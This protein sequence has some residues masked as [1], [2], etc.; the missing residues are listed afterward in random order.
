MANTNK[1]VGFFRNRNIFG[2]VFF[3]LSIFLYA[4]N[5]SAAEYYDDYSDVLLV[6]NDN[7]EISGQIADYFK[8]QRN[9]PDSHVVHLEC[10]TNQSI[11]RTEFE[12]SVR[13]PIEDFLTNNN[14]TNQINYIVLTKDVPLA[15]ANTDGSGTTRNAASVDS[16]LTLILGDYNSSLGAKGWFSNPYYNQE[17]PFS[18]QQFGFYLVTRLDGYTYDDIKALIDHATAADDVG[19]FVLDSDNNTNPANEYYPYDQDIVNAA[20]VIEANGYDANLEQTTTFLRNQTNV[21][22]YASWGSNSSGAA[23]A[24]TEGQPHVGEPYN[25]WA[26]GA[27]GDTYVSTSGRTFDYAESNYDPGNQSLS[28]DLV[29][30]GITGVKGYVGEPYATAM[31][32]SPILFGRYTK[33]YNLADSFYMASRFL[34]WQ[35]VVIGD[36]KTHI[37]EDENGFNCGGNVTCECGDVVTSNITLTADLNCTGLTGLIAGAANITI[38]GNGHSITGDDTASTN[39]IDITGFDNI[40]VKNFGDVSGF[41][42]GINISNSDSDTIKDNTLSSNT[43][44]LVLSSSTGDDINGNTVESNTS[45][46]VSLTSSEADITNN[47]ISSND[48]GLYFS[49]ST[50]NTTSSNTISSN[51]N[52]GIYLINS[53]SND[54]SENTIASQDNAG[55]M[56]ITSDSNT[57]SENSLSQ[58]NTGISFSI[59]YL[60]SIDSNTF[61]SNWYCLL[62]S[63]GSEANYNTINDNTFTANFDIVSSIGQ[64]DAYTGNTFVNN[65]NDSVFTS[66]TFSDNTFIDTNYQYGAY[67]WL[68]NDS[69]RTINFGDAA[70]F[71]FDLYDDWQSSCPD[72]TFTVTTSPSEIVTTRQN[73]EAVTG[74]FTPSRKGVYTLKITVT[75][76]SGNNRAEKNLTFLVG[77][78]ETSAVKYYLRD[79]DPTHYRNGTYSLSS[80]MPQSQ[81]TYSLGSSANFYMDEIPD[82]PL[83]VISGVKIGANYKSNK[84][85]AFKMNKSVYNYG[86]ESSTGTA[87]IAAD[88]SWVEQNLSGIDWFMDQPNSWYWLNFYASSDSGG[89]IFFKSGG[90]DSSYAEFSLEHLAD[91]PVKSISNANIE[92]LSATTPSEDT[93]DVQVILYNPTAAAAETE[94]TLDNYNHPFQNITTT[95]SSEGTAILNSGLIASEQTLTLNAL[96]M[97][98]VPSAGSID[99]EINNWNTNGDYSKEWTESSSSHSISSTHTIGDLAA[100]RYYNV[101]VDNGK[102][103]LSGCSDVGSNHV[104]QAD[105]NGEINFTYS[106]G[107]STHTFRVEEN[108]WSDTELDTTKIKVGGESQDFEGKVSVKENKIKLKQEDADLAGGTVKIYKD[109]KLWKT[110][111]TDTEGAWDKTLKFKDDFSN[112]I[113]IKFYNSFGIMVGSQKAKIKVDTEKPEFQDFFLPWRVTRGTTIINYPATDNNKIS[114]YKIYL[115]GKIFKTKSSNWKISQNIP[116]GLHK[117]KIRAYDPAGNTAIEERKI[118][119]R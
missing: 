63:S 39:G 66:G 58:N 61:D 8:A 25:S 2:Y 74:S 12:D 94:V 46:G 23:A 3:V 68:V 35:D 112:W 15:I 52:Y 32:R 38:D 56:L 11:T 19:T 105:V 106:G 6:T 24:V 4:S 79:T 18:S 81:E 29:A 84:S 5:V 109:N 20:P 42:N 31:A 91:N 41:A 98:V 71:S 37:V 85:V 54:F 17:V 45:Y 119:V 69:D 101:S 102:S 89:N 96:N 107:Y 62:D 80:S 14:L 87:P 83:S 27:I 44:G 67:I 97:E 82:Y 49:G 16:D 100:N 114:Y 99:V 1:Q 117:I 40:T 113:K 111:V 76:A 21:L 88:Y 26:P 104:C 95:I 115:G 118:W 22:G 86:T 75:S 116:K 73:G 30:E 108:T 110:I 64:Y 50:G 51:S 13:G 47:E 34:S 10:S 53:D 55:I 70:N 36:P 77:E 28:A 78:T 93:S 59:S 65:A 60:N 7:S 9:I 90:N 72:C 33:G 48:Y 43:K 57:F 103:G 92:V